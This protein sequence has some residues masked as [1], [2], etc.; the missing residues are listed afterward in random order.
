MMASVFYFDAAAGFDLRT[1]FFFSLVR[2]PPAAS[3]C[4]LSAPNFVFTPDSNR[5]W[6]WPF[7][8]R[9]SRRASSVV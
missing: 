9:G 7:R 6:H 4:E 8:Y 5:R 2:V 3:Y 1:G